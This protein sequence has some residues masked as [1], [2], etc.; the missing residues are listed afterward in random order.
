MVTFNKTSRSKM[1]K[2]MF[3][4]DFLRVFTM[5]LVYIMAAVS[6]VMPVLIIVMTT[7][8][9]GTTADPVTGAETA[10]QSFTNVWQSI[11]SVSGDS[12]SSAMDIVSMCN[13]NLIYI[14]AAVFVC[15]FIAGDF[16]SGYAKNIFTVRPY[17]YDYVISKTVIGFTGGAIMLVC[18]FIG[19]M[20]GGAIA[21]LS[22]DAEEA[23]A[24]GIVMCMLSKIFLMLV[25][26]SIY[27]VM[28]AVAK[29]RLWLSILLS[30]GASMLLFTM[31]PMI[32]PLDSNFLNVVMCLIGGALFAAGL[33]AVSCVVLKKTSIV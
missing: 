25:F 7:M 31:I 11:A 23:G 29:Q 3:K 16:T 21:G 27:T 26:V 6:L 1:I 30:L 4:A 9:S 20:A 8:M 24:F 12:S 14:L 22:F 13:I 5:P 2:S 10:V 28:G 32:T 18:Y 17:R 15:I 19:A 33:G